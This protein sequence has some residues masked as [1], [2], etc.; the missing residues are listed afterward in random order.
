MQIRPAF[1]TEAAAISA[2]AIR[3]KAHWGYPEE[4]MAIFRQELLLP[5]EQ[6]ASKQTH[7][8]IAEGAIAGYYTL[9]PHD[10]RTLELEHLFIEPTKLHQGYGSQLFMHACKVARKRKFQVLVI[11]SDPNAGG[12][13]RVLG[14]QLTREIPSSIPGRFIPHFQFDLEQHIGLAINT[15]RSYKTT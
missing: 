9:L 3:S 8:L 11:Q 6:V 1:I 5:E 7:V 10:E 13:Y 4:Q 12:F 14:A 2:L 15:S